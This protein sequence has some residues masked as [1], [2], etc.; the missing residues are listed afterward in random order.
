M[1]SGFLLF[2]PDASYIGQRVLLF[3]GWN[4][5]FCSMGVQGLLARRGTKIPVSSVSTSV[6]KKWSPRLASILDW[7]SATCAVSR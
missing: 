7:L 2:L 5:Q 1:S 6:C 4:R 3:V